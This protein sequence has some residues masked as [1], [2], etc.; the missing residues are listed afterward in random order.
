MGFEN[1]NNESGVATLNT[2]LAD[3]S[4]IEGYNL[5]Q[6]DVAVFEAVSGAPAAKFPHAA[7]WFNHVASHKAAFASYAISICA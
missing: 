2:Y 6:A 7:R 5:S 4:Y 3:K 1:L